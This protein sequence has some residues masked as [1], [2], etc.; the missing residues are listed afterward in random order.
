MSNLISIINYNQNS[1]KTVTALNLAASLAIYEKKTLLIDASSNF[2]ASNAIKTKSKNSLCDLNFFLNRECDIKDIIFNT[3]LEFL[4]FIPIKKNIVLEEN[5]SLS[6]NPF[7]HLAYLLEKSYDYIIYDTAPLSLEIGKI[8][9]GASNRVIIPMQCKDGALDNLLE[10]LKVIK[11]IQNVKNIKLEILGIVF[12]LTKNYSDIETFF[13]EE[14]LSIFEKKIFKT[15]IPYD[16]I[17]KKHFDKAGFSAISDIESICASAYL[18]LA[19]EI[20]SIDE[21]S[22]RRKE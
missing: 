1:C 4:D 13:K 9:A 18:D 11:D 14:A 8:V 15:Q 17:I 16:N 2:S 10:T 6:K 20:I 5:I 21:A 3:E 12:T 22:V 19:F 7:E